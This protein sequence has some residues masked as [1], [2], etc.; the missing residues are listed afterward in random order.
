M[1]SVILAEVEA[2][3]AN[4]TPSP[5][6]LTANRIPSCIMYDDNDGREFSKGCQGE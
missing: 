4:Q 2:D 3:Y 1:S 6:T 5:A